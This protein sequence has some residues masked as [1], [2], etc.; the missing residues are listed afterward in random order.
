MSRRIDML[1]GPL[2]GKIIAFALPVAASSILQQLFNSVDV[3]VVGKFS[4]PQALAAVGSNGSLI[5]LMINLF[6]GISVGANV[7]IS[8]YIG[9]QDKAGMKRAISTA[10]AVSVVSG[11]LLLV[12]GVSLARVILEAMQTPSDV[13]DLSVLYLR[14]YFLGMP[15]IMLFNFTSAIFRSVGDTKR[16]LYCLMIGGLVNVVVNLVLVLA[17]HF[18]V[19]GVAI[20]T[21]LGN[22][23]AAALVLFLLGNESGSISFRLSKARIFRSEL[24]E[25][26]RIGI[27]AGVQS[28]VFSF[29]NVFIQASINGFGAI[30]VAGSAAALN[31]EHYCYYIIGAF[32][33]ATTTFTGQNHGAGQMDRCRKVFWHAMWLSVVGCGVCNMFFV[34]QERWA[35]GLFTSDEAVFEYAFIRMEII[36]FWQWIA[37]SY[38]I[39]AASLRGLGYSSLPALLTIFGTCVLRIG[40]IKFY[41]P[42]HPDF[43][44]LMIVYPISWIITGTL[45]LTANRIVFRREERKMVD[46][47]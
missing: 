37:C 28:M 6:V 3:A 27:P 12:I 14:V 10:L 39:S 43:S 18:D 13:I 47:G 34:W 31:Y 46:C 45:V 17:F 8:R 29:A 7:V 2:L 30:A 33:A 23:V 19:L 16:P 32:V 1:N 26:L 20:G 38:E 15:A 44:S 9:K 36:L 11:L 5:N 40:W 22:V 24:S 4:S 25:M 42:T 35:I 41:C 21:V